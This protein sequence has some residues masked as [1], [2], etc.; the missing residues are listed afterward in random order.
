MLVKPF[1]VGDA[2]HVAI[3]NELFKLRHCDAERLTDTT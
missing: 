3:E 1:Q 2:A